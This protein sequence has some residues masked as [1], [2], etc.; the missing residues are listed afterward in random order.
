MPVS[1]R[2]GADDV[3]CVSSDDDHDID[4]Y[5]PCDDA[6]TYR[7]QI[8]NRSVHQRGGRVRPSKSIENRTAD[9]R[10]KGR[11]RRT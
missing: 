3:D 6:R 8:N 4:A 11:R 5:P 7:N 9:R 1:R 10:S 2:Y